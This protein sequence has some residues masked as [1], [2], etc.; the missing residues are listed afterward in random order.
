MKKLL[1]VCFLFVLAFAVMPFCA[2]ALCGGSSLKTVNA[3]NDSWTN[4]SEFDDG[5]KYF[6]SYDETSG[7]FIIKDSEATFDKDSVYVGAAYVLP[8]SGILDEY[9][10]FKYEA[11]R[12]VE[13]DGRMQWVSTDFFSVPND[14]KI[15]HNS[16]NNYNK[17]ISFSL[18]K[19]APAGRYGVRVT[20]YQG[21]T[22]SL[23]YQNAAPVYNYYNSEY[24]ILSSVYVVTY[25]EELGY[26][27]CHD[28]RPDYRNNSFY[29]VSEKGNGTGTTVKVS[30]MVNPGAVSSEKADVA[31]VGNVVVGNL[32]LDSGISLNSL[33]MRL[34]DERGE[35][36]EDPKISVYVGDG[37]INLELP[38][39]LDDGKYV[40]RVWHRSNPKIVG[41]FLID[42]GGEG[43]ESSSTAEI[44]TVL[45]I[46]GLVVI[47]FGGVLFLWPRVQL[48]IQ[49]G[50]AEREE[51]RRLKRAG[52]DAKKEKEKASRSAYQNAQAIT[53]QLE[54]NKN[55]SEAERDELIAKRNEEYS[56]TKSGGF[57]QKL[58]DSRLKREIARDAGLSMEEF[59]ELEDKKLKMEEAQKR[60]LSNLRSELSEP[61]M[62]DVNAMTNAV[63]FGKF[64]ITEQQE[65][66]EKE[67]AEKGKLSSRGG[68]EGRTEFELLD[69]MK[70]SV[71]NQT[72]LK[73]DGKKTDIEKV[74]ETN[75]EAG[76]TV[77]KQQGGSLL[78]RIRRFTG[79]E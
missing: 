7:I 16:Y 79:E 22:A 54:E 26:I 71:N 51:A 68:E 73:S 17:T 56:K 18:L 70:D 13:I 48:F 4:L 24:R 66:A 15:N 45:L 46:F 50:V 74:I 77:E 52:I 63:S 67:K 10:K 27:Y 55:L 61:V 20:A 35:E 37:Y 76:E 8:S 60:G 1:G 2:G 21:G 62:E 41:S 44:G 49:T 75:I 28:A 42:N 31:T 25:G 40:L 11:L 36:L 33:S 32:N 39:D 53:K 43:G 34:E 69:S 29:K 57:L 58:N 64:A 3:S 59:K 47:A 65:E 78:D 23:D 30:V 5:I 6:N 38:K 14:G 9:D 19:N 72:F 12:E